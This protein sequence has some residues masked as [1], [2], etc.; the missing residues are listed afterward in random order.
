MEFLSLTLTHNA[1]QESTD[2]GALL[3]EMYA[4][5]AAANDVDF[6]T[7]DPL[8]TFEDEISTQLD[9]TGDVRKLRQEHGVHRLVR[10]MPSDPKGRRATSFC[11]VAVDEKPCGWTDRPVRSYVLEPYKKAKQLNSGRETDS[12]KRLLAGELELLWLEFSV[13]D[14]Q[15]L[16][17]LKVKPLCEKAGIPYTTI[18]SKMDRDSEFSEDESRLLTEALRPL[19]LR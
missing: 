9:F 1:G 3:K 8:P 13:Y 10:I 4:S 14:L 6:A 19:F 17:L 7:T 12:V 5:W 16:D 18:K 15:R 11:K 2:F